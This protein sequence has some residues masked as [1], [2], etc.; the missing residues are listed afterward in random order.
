[1]NRLTDYCDIW[2][3]DWM[4]S[5]ISFTTK[6]WDAFSKA[7]TKEFQDKDMDQ[8]IHTQKYLEGYK[9]Q[10]QDERSIWEYIHEYTAL[11]TKVK[12]KQLIDGPTQT[13]WFIDSLPKK[14]WK[15]VVKKTNIDPEDP[16]TMDFDSTKRNTIDVMEKTEQS[17]K[18][19]NPEHYHPEV[20]QL[21]QEYSQSA[22]S[23][24]RSSTQATEYPKG[25]APV[26]S[27]D[28]DGLTHQ[29]EALHLPL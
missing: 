19:I 24:L 4:T 25:K 14:Y 5:L 12:T 1:M 6:D 29:I 16:M 2:I 27:S 23:I 21:A 11:S 18:L 9:H 26:T 22:Q 7:V 10:H 3:G 15:Q 17:D 8:L 20:S 28:I 13:Q